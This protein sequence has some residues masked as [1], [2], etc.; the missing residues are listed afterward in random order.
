MTTVTPC[1]WFDSEAEE[2]ANFYTTVFPDAHILTIAPYGEAGAKASG[3]PEG[4]VM[5]VLFQIGNQQFMALNGGPDFKFTPA[6]SLMVNCKSQEEIDTLWK[7]LS[8]GGTPEQCGWLRDRYGISWQIVPAELGEMMTD[9]DTRRSERVTKAML[10]MDK[11]D[12]A[13]LKKAYKG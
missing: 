1:L 6:I 9:P 4:S 5:T 8:A 3:K 7:K 12:M 2:A 11:L 13:A 10:K